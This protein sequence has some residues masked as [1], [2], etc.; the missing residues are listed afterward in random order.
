MREGISLPSH[1]RA[2]GVTSASF[3]GSAGFSAAFSLVQDLP[4]VA[5]YGSGRSSGECTERGFGPFSTDASARMLPPGL[6]GHGKTTEPYE[7]DRRNR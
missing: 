3:P 4:P 7:A 5:K 1:G 6:P 2:R